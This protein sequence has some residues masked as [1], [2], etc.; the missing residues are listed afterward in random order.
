MALSIP[1]SP[2]FGPL[3][4]SLLKSKA[5]VIFLAFLSVPALWFVFRAQLVGCER[6]FLLA[7]GVLAAAGYLLA[8][9]Y[10]LRKFIHRTPFAHEFAMR[11]PGTSLDQAEI[12][13]GVLRREISEGKHSNRGAIVRAANAIAKKNGVHKVIALRV[14]ADDDEPGGFGVQTLPRNPLGKTARWFETHFFLGLACPILV[15]FHGQGSL[16]S[17]MA[18]ALNTLAV[19]VTVTGLFGLMLWLKTPTILTRLE[20]DLSTEEAFVL[21]RSLQRQLNTR[22]GENAAA[23]SAVESFVARKQATRDRAETTRQDLEQAGFAAADAQ[24]VTVLAAQLVSVKATLSRLDRV[25]RRL[26]TWKYVH[27]PPAVLLMALVA[28][29]IVSVFWY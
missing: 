11:V 10:A 7:T 14:V 9:L 18:I 5:W 8:A 2:D 29:H 22:V 26:T 3:H 16:D 12:E 4:R 25:R 21:S 23:R 13:L 1:D 17:T 15:L 20:S 27:I 6:Y 19:I 24:D 28:I